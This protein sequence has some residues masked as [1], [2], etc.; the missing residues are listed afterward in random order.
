MKET[1]V[2]RDCDELTRLC[3]LVK[4]SVAEGKYKSCIGLICQAMERYPHAPEPHNLLGIILEKTGD[5]LT[6]MKH[7]R[8]ARAL[9]PTYRPANY[10]LS[11]Y[12]TFISCGMC[13]FDESDVPPEPPNNIEIEYD[14]CGVDHVVYKKNIEYDTH[15]VGH[16]TR[17]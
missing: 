11:T 4:S 2:I 8:A 15:G 10:N 1:N 14:K 17:R 9:D 3:A 6:A 12:G 13:A 5:H 7:F 16:V